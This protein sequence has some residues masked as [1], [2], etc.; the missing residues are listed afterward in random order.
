MS[1]SLL[2]LANAMILSGMM[3]GGSPPMRVDSLRGIDIEKE[4]ELINQKKSSLSRRE[5]E[6]VCSRYTRM[7]KANA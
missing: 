7:K 2:F 3:G 1:S 5:R 4:M 6:I